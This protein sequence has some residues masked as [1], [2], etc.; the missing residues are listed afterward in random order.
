MPIELMGAILFILIWLA[1]FLAGKASN[2][3]KVLKEI[4]ECQAGLERIK[5]IHKQ[6]E[7]ASE[8]YIGELMSENKKLEMQ[9]EQYKRVAVVFDEGNGI[10][11]TK[12]EST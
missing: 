10:R 5:A 3:R 1:G 9:L 4:R 2:A 6:Y 12:E 8:R 11:L 7:D